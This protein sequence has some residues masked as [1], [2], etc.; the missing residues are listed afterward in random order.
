MFHETLFYGKG[1][2]KSAMVY[3]PLDMIDDLAQKQIR[4]LVDNPALSEASLVFMPDTHGG[5][6]ATIG[7]TIKFNSL[8]EMKVNPEWVGNDIACSVAV[9]RLGS[10]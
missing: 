10:K 6:G 3:A 7:T 4:E 5:K 8:E 2:K 9:F 1:N